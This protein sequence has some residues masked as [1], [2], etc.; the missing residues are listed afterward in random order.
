MAREAGPVPG[1]RDG[2]EDNP[3]AGPAQGANAKRPDPGE[4]GPP[5]AGALDGAER[6][7]PYFSMGTRTMLPHSV[8]EPS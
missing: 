2:P 3:P 1:G 8:Q 5:G 7:A 6:T 4:D